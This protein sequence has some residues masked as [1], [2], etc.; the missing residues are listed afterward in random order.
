MTKT[1]AE[2]TQEQVKLARHALGL[3]NSKTSFRNHFVT[4]PGNDDHKSW[5]DMVNKGFADVKRKH[6]LSAGMDCFWLT[7]VGAKAVLKCGEKL[8]KEDFPNV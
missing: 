5:D 3:T 2:L 6:I 7:S 1:H 4:S 8:C